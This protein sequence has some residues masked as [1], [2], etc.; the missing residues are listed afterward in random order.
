VA[1]D[2]ADSFKAAGAE[3]VIA[4]TLADAMPQAELTCRD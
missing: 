4:R 1:L 2:I 3:V